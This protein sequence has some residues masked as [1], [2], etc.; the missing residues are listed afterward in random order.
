MGLGDLRGGVDRRRLNGCLVY[1]HGP[2][3]NGGKPRIVGI[4]HGHLDVGAGQVGLIIGH[5]IET[6]SIQEIQELQIR[7]VGGLV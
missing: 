1:S 6:L 3:R 2:T 7:I 5:A 4:V